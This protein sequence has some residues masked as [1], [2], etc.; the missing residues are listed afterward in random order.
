MVD[1]PARFEIADNQGE[2]LQFTGSVG[3][4][5]E[6]FPDPAQTPISEFIIQ[7]PEEQAID[8]RLFVSVNG[9]DFITLKPSGHLAWSP[10]GQ[11][12]TQLTIK[13][14]IVTGV[15]YEMLLNLE[16]D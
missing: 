2:T 4:V 3:T 15:L 16:V 14:N 6:V 8:N 13:G 11:S 9:T 12:V 10:K 5:P 7:C 1:S